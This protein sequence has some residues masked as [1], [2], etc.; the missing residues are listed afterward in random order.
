MAG[1]LGILARLRVRHLR[2]DARFLLF[3][4]G[5]DIDEDRGFLERTYQVYLLTIFAVSL[6]LSWAQVIDIVEGLRSALGAGT[7]SWLASMLLMLAPAVAFLAWGVSGIRETPIR[8]TGP[9]IAWLA[10]VARPE[11]L[12]VVQLVGSAVGIV[13]V[14]ALAG[15]LLAALAGEPWPVWVTAAPLAL[16][17]ARLFAFDAVLHDLDAI[18]IDVGFDKSLSVIPLRIEHHMNTINKVR[19]SNCKNGLENNFMQNYSRLIS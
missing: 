8:L 19:S 14:G 10:R 13:F 11:E 17:T 6:A 12:F 1:H 7:S 18:V 2:S 15:T 3:A 16:I 5:A 4:V 9:D